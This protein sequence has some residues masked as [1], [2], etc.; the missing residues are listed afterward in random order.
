MTENSAEGYTDDE[1]KKILSGGVY[2]GAS[3]AAY[4]TGRGFG[5]Y[6]GFDTG[7]DI[8]VDARE[9]YVNHEMNRGITG[10][11]RNCRQ[12]FNHGESHELIPLDDK[13]EILS[14]LVDYHDRVLAGACTGLYAERARR[15][16]VRLDILPI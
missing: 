10:C 13:C 14:R 7:R 1:L 16:R 12:A 3:A 9:E 15:A 6:L 5:K 11:R 8:P 2:V 4:L